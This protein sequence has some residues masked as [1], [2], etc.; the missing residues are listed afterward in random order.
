M[1][2]Q[3]RCRRE[4]GSPGGFARMRMVVTVILAVTG[5]LGSRKTG[6]GFQTYSA[7]VSIQL[8]PLMNEW[9]VSLLAFFTE[10]F[11]STAPTVLSPM[12]C[13]YSWSQTGRQPLVSSRFGYSQKMHS[14]KSSVDIY[15]HCRSR[16]LLDSNPQ[17]IFVDELL[18]GKSH[19]CSSWNGWWVQ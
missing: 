2:R 8:A 5:K 10:H 16:C 9:A 1:C 12:A 17:V 13:V 14:C 19:P 18:Q 3:E 11:I 6:T 7:R 4:A 15:V